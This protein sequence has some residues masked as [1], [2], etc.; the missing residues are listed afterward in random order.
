MSDDASK[1]LNDTIGHWYYSLT[2]HCHLDPNT[3][4]LVQGTQPLGNLSEYIWDIMDAVPPVSLN[5]YFDPSR[6]NIFSQN[7]GAVVNALDSSKSSTILAA[8]QIWDQAG[9]YTSIKAYD[10]TISMLR[11]QI[12]AAISCSFSM[13]IAKQPGVIK[14]LARERKQNESE[15]FSNQLDQAIEPTSRKLLSRASKVVTEFNHFMIFPVGPLA[16]ESQESYL[17]DFKPWYLSPALNIA[18][19][20]QDAWN[21]NKFPTWHDTFGDSGNMLRRCTALV[22]VDGVKLTMTSSVTLNAEQK[23]D[24]AENAKNSVLPQLWNLSSVEKATVEQCN[25]DDCSKVMVSCPE[26]NPL[27]LGVIVT[28]APAYISG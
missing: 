20:N 19:Q 3:F 22:V 7:Y 1:Q 12:Q 21:P 13:D 15:L 17:K 27:L 11:D 5:H 14:T 23:A 16:K 24:F 28:P 6:A 9:G 26:G 2:R 25:E 18:Y 4:Q 8:V 10:K